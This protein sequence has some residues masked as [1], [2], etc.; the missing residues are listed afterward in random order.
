MT[1]HTEE[2]TQRAL[3]VALYA[4]HLIAGEDAGRILDEA[5]RRMGYAAR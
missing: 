1:D 4:I 5:A 3:D 2:D